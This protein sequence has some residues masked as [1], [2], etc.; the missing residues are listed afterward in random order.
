MAEQ[1]GRHFIRRC[2]RINLEFGIGISQVRIEATAGWNGNGH[3]DVEA[4]SANPDDPYF[5]AYYS[6]N[7][8]Y[9]VDATGA[10]THKI[11]TALYS[12]DTKTFDGDVSHAPVI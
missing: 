1:L 8:L 4:Y 3:A 9:R 11:A 10:V 2:R 5:L 12:F 7:A 6:A